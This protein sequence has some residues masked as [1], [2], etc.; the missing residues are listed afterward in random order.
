MGDAADDLE[1]FFEQRGFENVGPA[2]NG[3]AMELVIPRT[4]PKESGLPTSGLLLVVGHPKSGKTWFAS[5]FPD[6]YILELERGGADRVP[7]GRIHDIENL[8]AFG[9]VLELVVADEGIKT[10]TIDSVDELATWI[11]KDVEKEKPRDK[12]GWAFWGEFRERIEGLVDFLKD[13]GKLV[14]LIAHCKPPEK[15]NEGRVIT[16]AGINVS[17]KGGAYIAAQAEMIGYISKKNLGGKGVHFLS[18]RSES[19][20]A[21]WGSRVEELADKEIQLSK[22]DP[23]GSFASIFENGKPKEAEPVK[24]AP[25]TVSIAAKRK[26]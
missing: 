12:D 15:T 1:L 8:E 14:I 6:S 7:G 19:D 26:K 10:I 13:S 3:G 25:K 11:E 24:L 23:Y 20:L 5:S 18:F 2:N 9:Q 4:K 21:I 16:P 17:G 22:N